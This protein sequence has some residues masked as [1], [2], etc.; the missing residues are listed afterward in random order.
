MTETACIMA[1][2]SCSAQET[3]RLLSSA[4]GIIRNTIKER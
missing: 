4:C 1:Y 3:E 2:K